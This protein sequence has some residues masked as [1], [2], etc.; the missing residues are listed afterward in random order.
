MRRTGEKTQIKFAEYNPLG[1]VGGGIATLT[2]RICMDKEELEDKLQLLRNK[3]KEASE[4]DRKIIVHQAKLLKRGLEK[5]M[6][7]YEVAKKIFG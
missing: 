1:G 5:L 7:A 3:Y 6:S 4:S 2:T